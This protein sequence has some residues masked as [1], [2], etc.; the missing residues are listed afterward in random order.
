M[1]S[2]SQLYSN[3]HRREFN[4]VSSTVTYTD[5]TSV[6]QF[7]SNMHRRDFNTVSSTVTYTEVTSTQSDLQQRK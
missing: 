1:T 3:M 2:V 5:V 6:S 7:Y 4:T